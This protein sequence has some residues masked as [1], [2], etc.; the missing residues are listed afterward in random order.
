MIFWKVLVVLSSVGGTCY[1]W[2][3]G[4]EFLGFGEDDSASMGEVKRDDGRTIV[5]CME[6]FLIF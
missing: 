2:G 3:R 1:I 5:L 4:E 6:C